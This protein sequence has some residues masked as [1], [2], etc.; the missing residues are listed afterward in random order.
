M[1]GY[2]KYQM[3]D[4]EPKKDDSVV[5]IEGEVVMDG[6][7]DTDWDWERWQKHFTE[8]DEQERV[9]SILKVFLLTNGREDLI[10]P[11]IT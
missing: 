4:D 2:R 10:M 1:T 7:G 8:V 5:K 9:V 6:D 3:N 11:W